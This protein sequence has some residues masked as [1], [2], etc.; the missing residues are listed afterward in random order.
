MAQFH[1][2]PN[3]FSG[4]EVMNSNLIF[5]LKWQPSKNTANSCPFTT[6]LTYYENEVTT[7]TMIGQTL[8]L[9]MHIKIVLVWSCHTHYGEQESA[10]FSNVTYVHL[11]SGNAWGT[12]LTKADLH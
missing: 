5:P 1:R 7:S 8:K 12:D 11:N 4:T 10:L 9:Q 2:N 6:F 3:Q